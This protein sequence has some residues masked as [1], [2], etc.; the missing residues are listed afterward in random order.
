MFTRDLESRLHYIRMNQ[1]HIRDTECAS[2]GDYSNMGTVYL[3]SSF[4]GSRRWASKQIADGL[5]LA[6]TFGPPTFFATFTCNPHWLEIKSQLH[7]GQQYHDI[8]IVV[9][10]VFKQRFYTS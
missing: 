7:P 10:R 6:A 9:T 2:T 3:P 4:L 5:A 8:P 1:N